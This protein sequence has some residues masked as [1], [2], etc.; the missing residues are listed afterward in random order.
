MQTN[1]KNWVPNGMI[2]GFVGATLVTASASVALSFSNNSAVAKYLS[3]ALGAASIAMACGSAWCIYRTINFPI[4]E[5]ENYPNISLMVSHII[6]M[7]QRAGHA[8]ISDAVVA[9]SRLQP[10]KPILVQNASVVIVGESN[11]RVF[12]NNCVKITLSPK[13]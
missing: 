3:Y 4:M 10:Q 11:M 2:S 13:I 6:S 12:Q 9:L 1:Y 7:F 8:L 5:N